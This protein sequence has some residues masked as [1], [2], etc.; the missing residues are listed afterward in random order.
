MKTEI[1][2]R[3]L[4]SLG[5]ELNHISCLSPLMLNIT[6]WLTNSSAAQWV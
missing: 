3:P 2:H 4:G 1:E 5:P 6:K